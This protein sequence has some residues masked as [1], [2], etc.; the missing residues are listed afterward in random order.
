M[1]SQTPCYHEATEWTNSPIIAQVKRK[2]ST[3]LLTMEFV[4]LQNVALPKPPCTIALSANLRW[5]SSVDPK[6]FRL[7]LPNQS[8]SVSTSNVVA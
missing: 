8:N 7:L 6:S 4:F 1:Y 5:T 3:Y 2:T